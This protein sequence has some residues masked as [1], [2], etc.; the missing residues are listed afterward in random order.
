MSQHRSPG[1]QSSPEA[2]DAARKRAA[3]R[4][5]GAHRLSTPSPA[6]RGR[7]VIAA[8]AAGAFVAAGQS[9]QFGLDSDGGQAYGAETTNLAAGSDA[10]PSASAG[11]YSGVGGTMIAPEVLPIAQAAEP[12]AAVG[13]I[14]KGQQM[15]VE[16][17]AAE[18]EAARPKFWAPA[19]GTYT[20]GYGARWGTTHYGMDI[21]NAIGT[22][23]LAAHDGVV[24]ETGPASGFGLWVRVQAADGTVTVYGHI[25]SYSVRPGQQV[26]AGEQIAQMGNRGFSTGPHLHFEVWAPG[27]GKKINPAAWLQERGVQT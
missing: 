19:Q 12:G 20:S 16:T 27:D 25:D 3:T 1:G 21:A 9:T 4:N 26:Q 8:V 18:A 23:I 14:V 10:A 5:R 13:Q 24:I 2:R 6:L 15:E 22:P 11:G 7:F 17:A